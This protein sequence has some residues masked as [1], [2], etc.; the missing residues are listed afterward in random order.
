MKI[1][2]QV[3]TDEVA[4]ACSSPEKASRYLKELSHDIAKEAKSY[5]D[6]NGYCKC[7]GMD[8]DIAARFYS[9]LNRFTNWLPGGKYDVTQWDDHYCTFISKGTNAFYPDW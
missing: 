3:D 4:E 1:K 7:K 6:F 8:Y 2:M 9:Y 5:F